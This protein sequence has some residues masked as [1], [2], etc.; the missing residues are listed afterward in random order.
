MC[1]LQLLAEDL[2]TLP[3][4]SGNTPPGTDDFPDLPISSGNPAFGTDDL[5]TFPNLFRKSASTPEGSDWYNGEIRP[6]EDLHHPGRIAGMPKCNVG[7][8]GAM[9]ENLVAVFKV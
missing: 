7:Y 8:K 9:F 2:Q 1:D 4:S 3:I 6:A 5:R